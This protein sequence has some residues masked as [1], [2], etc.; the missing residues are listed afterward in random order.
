MAKDNVRV[1]SIRDVHHCEVTYSENDDI[2]LEFIAR[3]KDRV[4]KVRVHLQWWIVPHLFRGI[5]KKWRE[6]R[7]SDDQREKE[8]R[9]EL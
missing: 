4:R 1:E 2:R 8:M 9:G 3:D 6:K 5:W 7:A